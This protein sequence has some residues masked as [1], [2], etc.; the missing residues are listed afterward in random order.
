MQFLSRSFH[1]R[2]A[3]AGLIT[4]ALLTTT[5]GLTNVKANEYKPRFKQIV[6]PNRE[7]FGTN[8]GDL[9]GKWWEWALNIPTESN[10]ILD[11]NG[12]DCQEG[13]FKVA[14]VFFL[15][16]TFGN[17]KPVTR[18]CTVPANTPL[19]LPLLNGIL[20]PEEGDTVEE[21]REQVNLGNELKNPTP[22]NNIELTAKINGRP[23]K[24]LF[25]Y[26]VQSP[27]GGFTIKFKEGGIANTDFGLDPGKLSPAVSDGY[28]LLLKPLRPG[29]HE[30][31][32]TSIRKSPN[33]KVDVIYILNVVKDYHP[34]KKRQPSH[35]R[36]NNRLRIP[37]NFRWHR[38]Q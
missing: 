22:E 20:I 28:W 12:E 23:V 8:Y 14:N 2:R 16:G 26:R 5:V 25:A 33:L 6:P 15:A 7:A 29:K 31:R 30:I 38:S 24:D 17:E 32:F 36:R 1:F 34:R 35:H 4:A 27:P 3:S 18:E 9:V 37:K 21:L 11:E 10:P 13:Q 19:F